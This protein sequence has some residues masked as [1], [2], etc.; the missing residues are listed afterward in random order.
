[1][2]WHG[3]NKPPCLSQVKEEEMTRNAPKPP[4]PKPRPGDR[5]APQPRVAYRFTDWAMI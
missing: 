5:Q 4:V 2:L 1:M 3:W